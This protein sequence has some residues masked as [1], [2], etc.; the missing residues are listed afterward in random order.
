LYGLASCLAFTALLACPEAGRTQSKAAE[1]SARK[2]S[3]HDEQPWAYFPR[4]RE[5]FQAA[6]AKE[7]PT[8]IQSLGFSRLA[9]A[10]EPPLPVNPPAPPSEPIADVD[11][12]HSSPEEPPPS[13]GPAA[14]DALPLSPASG[15]EPPDDP[16][17]IPAPGGSAAGRR[18]ATGY[19]VPSTNRQ[20]IS[21]VM[22]EIDGSCRNQECEAAGRPG[23]RCAVC[24]RKS[25]CGGIS[26]CWTKR[27]KPRLQESHWGYADLFDER[28]LGDAVI[29]AMTGQIRHGSA[30][31]LMLYDY[32]F[33]AVDA[34]SAARL[35]PRGRIQLARFVDRMQSTGAPLK[36]QSAANRS[37][38]DT[39]RRQ[40]V[41]R[42]L[43]AYGV[44]DAQDRVKLA[45]VKYKAP[46][47]EALQTAQGL[48]EMIQSR[49]RTIKP[50]DSTGFLGGGGG[51]GGGGFGR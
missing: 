21:S 14:R 39:A 30:E 31:M 13:E 12:G 27:I 51:G 42:E 45:R 24:G 43:A 9:T 38:L 2:G 37:A 4:L 47:T 33:Y 18:G 48:Q 34:A 22:A 40:H 36:I 35:T 29:S 1:G 26:G 19:S 11:T 7:E 6:A 41:V 8:F 16:E 32:D 20:Y 49:G 3:Q 44:A 25:N 5:P 46:A 17:E 10:P 28:P 50:Q 23:H 15:A